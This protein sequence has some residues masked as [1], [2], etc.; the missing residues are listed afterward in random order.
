MKR[1]C[2][3]LLV[4]LF[5]ALEPASADTPPSFAKDI[6]PFLAKYCI[7]CHQGAKPKGGIDLTTY[8]S[9]K[10]GGISFD[11]FVPGKPDES[12]VVKSV[13]K[14]TKPVMPPKDKKQPSDDERKLLRAWIAAGARDDSAKAVGVKLPDLKSKVAAAPAVAALAYRPDGKL[15]AAGTYKEVVLINPD[16]GAEVA[17]LPGQTESVTALTFTRDGL[18]F[19]VASGSSGAAGRLRLYSATNDP[20]PLKPE[21]DIPAH[22]DIIHALVFSPDGKTLASTGYDRL[23]KL[24]DVAAGKEVRT[25]KDH[26]DTAYGLAFSPDGKLLASAAADRAVKIWDVATGKRLYSLGDATDWL[27]ALAWSPDGK[28]VAAAGVDKSI[29]IWEADADGGKLVHSVFAH[30]GPVVRLAYAADGKTLYSLGEDRVIKSWDTAKMAEKKAYDKQP[31]AALALAV[32]QDNKQLAVG[33]YDGALIF[34]DVDTG[35]RQSQPLPARPHPPKLNKLTPDSGQRGQ[36]VRVTVEGQNLDAATE[37]TSTLKDAKMA[38]HADGRTAKSFQFDVTLP[39]G[40]PAGNYAVTVRS[41]AGP[42]NAAS[43]AV[44]LFPAVA[45]QEPNDS[46]STGQKIALPVSIAG[47]IGKAGDVDYYRFEAAAGQEIGV[48][49]I[50]ADPAKLEPI[51]ALT[52]VNGNLVAESGTGLLGYRCEKAGTYA[53][54]IRDRDYRGGELAYRLHLG[55]IPIVTG[56]F[57]LGLQRGTEAE[58][59]L[60]GVHL[61]ASRFVKL[62]APADAAPGTRLPLGSTALGSPGVMVGEFPELRSSGASA[63]AVPGTGNGTITRAGQPDTWRFPARKGQRLIVEV[64]ARRLGSPLDSTIDILDAQ[65]KPVQRAVLRCVAKTYSTF[66]DHDSANPGIRLETWNELAINDYL[67]IGHELLRIR[68]LPKNPDDDCQFFAVTNQRV[69]YLDTTPT[70]HPNG[71]PMYKVAIHP[72]GTT[73]APNGLPV[74]PIFY[75]NDDGGAGYGKDSRLFFDPPADGDYQVRIGDARGQGGS[76]YAYRLTVRRPRPSFQVRFSPTNPAVWQGGAVPITISADRSDG[77]DDAID[78][79]LD[80]LPPGFSAPPTTIP[81]GELST[82]VALFAEPAATVPAGALPLKVTARAVIDGQAV[83]REVAGAVPQAVAPGD[84]VTTVVQS[85]VAVQPGKEVRLTVAIER[86]NGFTGRIPL[87]V[88]GLPHGVRVLDIGLNGILITERDTSRT[89]AIYCEPWVQPIEHPFVV[90]ARREGKNTE[91]AA[92]SVLLKITK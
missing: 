80:N 34:L 87:E 11:G 78:L 58:I 89:I 46:P 18:R 54:G 13:E 2:L 44:D 63:L 21:H 36:T 40:T 82:T 45:E 74:V 70:H 38:I 75:R 7:E 51:L 49:A 57:P 56:V 19:A 68:A 35:K 30:E 84:I 60:D 91:H 67:L 88:R 66:R 47:T 9:F 52:D 14:R 43:F 83:V 41:P 61:G 37:V 79:K 59:K 77:F 39:V 69:G 28:H 81:A 10:K 64:N 42:S 31:E 62:K 32:R 5:V 65:G 90:L 92:R 1:V 12:W 76:A 24:W 85:E 50:P 72:P 22:A 16:T 20:T 55:D 23:I 33:R 8:E 53:L 48:Q 73:F 6:K 3:L 26:S 4:F 25:L 86:K 71:T 15:L 27:Y 29:R 17:R